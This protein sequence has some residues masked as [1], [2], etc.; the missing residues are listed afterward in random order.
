MAALTRAG[1]FRRAINCG[2]ERYK[3]YEADTQQPVSKMDR[4]GMP[5]E[6]FYIDYA[7]ANFGADAADTIGRIFTKIDGRG[8]PEPVSWYDGPGTM[9]A[10]QPPWDKVKDRYA[11]V[12]ELAAARSAG[13]RSR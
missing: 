1:E 8:L 7:R 11:F 9:Q 12:D 10:N 5:V 6:A 2:G 3:D 13:T 4:R